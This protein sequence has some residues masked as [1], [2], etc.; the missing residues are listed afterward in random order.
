M[1]DLP[2]DAAVDRA[3]FDHLAARSQLAVPILMGSSV[4]GGDAGRSELSLGQGGTRMKTVSGRKDLAMPQRL[5]M[6]YWK[7][8]QMWLGKL[9]EFPDVMTQGETVEELEEN[10]KDAYRVLI[11]EDVPADHLTKEIAV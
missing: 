9:L 6:V 3:S 5:T 8:E 4:S 1:A 11:L 10:I 2:P 7:G